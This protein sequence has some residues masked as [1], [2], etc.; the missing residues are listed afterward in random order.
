MV[1]LRGID[2]AFRKHGYGNVRVLVINWMGTEEWI[3]YLAGAATFPVLQDDEVGA[4]YALYN[5]GK[6]TTLV[7]DA[8]GYVRNRWSY[9]DF[10][11]EA[12]VLVD[13]V[14]AAMN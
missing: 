10:D 13:A 5:A 9:L 3:S 4:V 7:L 11:A 14:V 2:G 6:D 1:Y 12:Q 8:N